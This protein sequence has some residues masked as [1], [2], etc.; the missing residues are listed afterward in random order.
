M[1][2]YRP[3]SNDNPLVLAS[4]SPRR[5]RLLTTVGIPFRTV[6][7]RVKEDE[8]GKS[9]EKEAMILAERKALAGHRMSGAFWT[10]GADTMV[11]V[12][13]E[14]LGKPADEADAKNMLLKLRGRTHQVVTGFSLLNPGGRPVHA[15]AVTTDVR[16]KSLTEGEIERYIRSGEPFGKAGAYAIQGIGAF[17]VKGITGS[18]TNVVGL[19]VCTLV[20]ALVSTGAM[21][22]FPLAGV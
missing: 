5:K 16:F 18:Y 6:A 7:S 11:V 3:I 13:K 19:P 20:E 1:T 14:I 12:G 8:A 2:D 15:E 22:A 17:L 9:P 10:L 21:M 4:A